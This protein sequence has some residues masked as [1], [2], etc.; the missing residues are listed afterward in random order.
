MIVVTGGAGFIGSNLIKGLND[1]G[2]DNI[3]VVDNLS[4]SE[5]HL[6]I[7]SLSIGDYIDKDDF[8][9]YEYS[10]GKPFKILH[11]QFTVID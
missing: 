8:L 10:G 7:N 1:A 5:K 9:D 4:N 3:I 6:N 2:E 11:Y